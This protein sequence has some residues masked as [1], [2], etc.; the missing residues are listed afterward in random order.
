MF[1]IKFFYFLKGYV[2]I[3]AYGKSVLKLISECAARGIKIYN[4]VRG[5]RLRFAVC[6]S[7]LPELEKTAK[8]TGA[9]V[10]VVRKCGLAYMLKS[11]RGR[12]L[13]PVGAL[14]FVL[15]FAVASGFLWDIRIE[16]NDKITDEQVTA[17]LS[18]IGVKPGVRLSK[19]PDAVTMKDHLIAG[20]ENVPWA[21]VYVEGV[22]AR[23]CI[24][25]GTVPPVIVDES[26]PCDIIASRDGFIT[27]MSVKKGMR[28]CMPGN[29]VN[30]GEV[31]ISGFVELGEE[32]EGFEVHADGQVLALTHHE[33]TGTYSLSEERPEFTGAE[34]SIFEVT[35]FS[36]SFTVL[37]KPD[38]DYSITTE[39]CFK[40]DFLA[41]H[42]GFSITKRTFREAV[43]NTVQ[44]PYE[45]VLE[46]AKRDLTARIAAELGSFSRLQSEDFLVSENG[47]SITV[48]AKMDFTESI[49]VCVPR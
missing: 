9:A 24:H 15:F 45:W 14:V 26:K 35:L 2:I 6:S 1:L 12:V 29:A 38:Y 21:W 49:G 13:F 8:E 3:E 33:Q 11:Y 23:V 43:R 30:A 18:E 44:L 5:E 10:K 46:Y 22:R 4:I 31:L 25:E 41:K 37:K 36:K 32:K 34:K 17:L 40:P 20:L 48:T 39:S 7:D 47:G 42:M 28:M 27:D 19:L 16:G